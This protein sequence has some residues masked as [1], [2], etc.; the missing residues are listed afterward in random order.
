MT[1]PRW[2]LALAA[3]A[4][5]VFGAV[6]GGFAQAAVAPSAPAAGTDSAAAAA[7]GALLLDSLVLASD[8]TSSGAALPVP[9]LGVRERLAGRVA[10]RFGNLRDH[11][12][13]G[14]LTVLD[15]DGKLVSYQLDHGT[16]SAIG[17][18]SITIA[19]AGGASVTVSTTAETR[20]RKDSNPSTL[21]NLKTGDEVVVRS[22]VDGGSA[23]AR[24]VVVPPAMPA[25]TSPSGGGNG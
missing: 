23:T 11:L 21:A 5:V 6:G 10:G 22:T 13:H 19:E 18:A 1:I 12:V 25:I 14:T 15:R 16:V 9:L 17:S 2:R 4:L 3:G 20:V 24:L 7:D 8:P